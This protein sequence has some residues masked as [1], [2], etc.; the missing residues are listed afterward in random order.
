MGHVADYHGSRLYVARTLLVHCTQRL[1]ALSLRA[2]PGRE[3]SALIGITALVGALTANYLRHGEF[4]G[5]AFTSGP[6]EGR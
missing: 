4:A 5:A 1:R 2:A 6:H 3:V